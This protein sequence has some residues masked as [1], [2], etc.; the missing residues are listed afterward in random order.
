MEKVWIRE[1]PLARP[2][3]RTFSLSALDCCRS[4]PPKVVGVAVDTS[5]ASVGSVPA[6]ARRRPRSGEEFGHRSEDQRPDLTNLKLRKTTGQR[7]DFQVSRLPLAERNGERSNYAT[8][9]TRSCR[10]WPAAR[11]SSFHPCT[12]A[13]TCSSPASSLNIACGRLVSS[14]REGVSWYTDPCILCNYLFA[15][16]AIFLCLLEELHVLGSEPRAVVRVKHQEAWCLSRW[17]IRWA[18]D[19]IAGPEERAMLRRRLGCVA[20][21]KDDAPAND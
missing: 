19:L 1:R 5:G 6:H 12:V 18:E 3:E 20:Y 14:A 17:C 7:G 16:P 10:W 2:L 4:D 9:Y 8:S 21:V 13:R 11:L 15:Y